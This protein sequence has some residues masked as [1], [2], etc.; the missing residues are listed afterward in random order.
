MFI[1]IY[2]YLL[3]FIYILSI[4][5]YLCFY[6]IIM[7]LIIYLCVFRW[8][9]NPDDP[10]AAH[11]LLWAVFLEALAYFNIH[12]PVSREV[13]RVFYPWLPLLLVSLF[14]CVFSSLFQSCVFIACVII[15]VFVVLIIVSV[16]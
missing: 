9:S 1:Y 2:I 6:I 7:F 3:V 8:P 5:D 10:L 14:L 11:S 12:L 4:V 16:S 13:V 15:W